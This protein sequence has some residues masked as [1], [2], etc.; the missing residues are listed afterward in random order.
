MDDIL[1]LYAENLAS[2]DTRTLVEEHLAECE[3]CRE[4]L[5]KMK[6]P[7]TVIAEE[8]EAI[9]MKK[10][11]KTLK[12]RKI[13]TICISVFL[14][15]ALIWTAAALMPVNFDYGDSELY[16]LH[17]RKEAARIVKNK[18]NSF[19]GCKLYSIHYE[20]DEA[21]LKELERQSRYHDGTYTDVI[22]FQSFFR[23]PIMGGGA[24][25]ANTMYSWSWILGRS[26]NGNWE[27]IG[28]GYG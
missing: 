23:S 6:L 22:V 2:E 8:N 14:V 21:S 18:I 26:G 11:K 1:P 24:W 20:G 16:T 28:W 27:L 5:E 4:K 25:N 15:V 12:K 7:N 13:L 10:L 19:E 9:P 3:I 17:E